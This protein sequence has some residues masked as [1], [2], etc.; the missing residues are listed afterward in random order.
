MRILHTSDWHIGKKLKEHDRTDEYRKFFDWLADIIASE[1]IDVLISAGDIFD[2]RNPSIESQEIY[3]SFLGKIAGNTCRHV[4]IT[5]GNHDSAAFIDAPSAL[6]ERCD[7]SVV[8][9]SSENEIITLNDAQGKL[10]LIVCAVP[11]LHEDDIKMTGESENFEDS[12]KKIRAGI[13]EHYAKIFDKA[14]ELQSGFDV[15]IVAMGHLFLDTSRRQNDEG[16]RTL[17]LGTAIEVRKDIFPDD[18]AYTALGH[19]HSPQKVGRSNIRYSGSPIAL[20]FGEL[21]VKKSVSIIDFDGKNFAGVREIHV[22]V[23]QKMERISGNM[24]GI[25]REI[26]AFIDK[27]ESTWLEVMYTGNEAVGDLRERLDEIVKGSLV[28]VLSIRNESVSNIPIVQHNNINPSDI[29]PMEMLERYYSE[30]NISEAKRE[31]FTPLYKE[32]LRE[33]EIDY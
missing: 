4:V 31:I 26:R 9:R 30:K 23:F 24:A 7:V 2:N 28:E 21:D 1:K 33:L 11:F 15:P 20:T 12:V 14:R 22:P 25:E 32:I 29:K 17:Y 8:G 16:E 10:E 27:N 6:M 5:A 13:A 3:Y 18:I 19:L